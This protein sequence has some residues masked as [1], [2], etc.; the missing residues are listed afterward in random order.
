MS[1]PSR[2]FDYDLDA[3][4]SPTLALQRR[5]DEIAAEEFE[6]AERRRVAFAGL[7]S[8]LSSPAER[9]RAW[10]KLFGLRLPLDARHAVLVCIAQS[11]GLTLAEVR[12]EQAS[13]SGR[14]NPGPERAPLA[15]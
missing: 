15:G 12:Y 11:T 6:R 7:K 9:I 3:G 5:A 8:D 10:E 13:R 4:P 14:A 1:S 2:L